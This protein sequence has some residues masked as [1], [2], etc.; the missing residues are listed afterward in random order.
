MKTIN[1]KLNRQN[2]S[3]YHIIASLNKELIIILID[4]GACNSH[5]SL[6][7]A[8]EIYESD[9]IS[10]E[11]YEGETVVNNKVT[12][13]ELILS[14]ELKI[15]LEIP[16]DHRRHQENKKVLLGI[17]FLEQFNYQIT[18][19]EL[20]LDNIRIPRINLYYKDIEAQLKHV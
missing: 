3:Q 10:Y 12:H 2:Y 15:S 1:V 20:I 8:Q 17:D 4:T 13:I 9:E 6:D 7:L 19:T 16:I 11:S 14:K 18:S 5:I